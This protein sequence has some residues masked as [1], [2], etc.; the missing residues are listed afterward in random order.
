[1]NERGIAFEAA[2][3]ETAGGYYADLTDLFCTADRCPVN[4]GNTLVYLDG[5]HP[6]FEYTGALVPVLWALVDHTLAGS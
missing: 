2:A 1:M 4:I 6:A 3:T 5:S